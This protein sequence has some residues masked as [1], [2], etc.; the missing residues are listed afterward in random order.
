MSGSMM[1]YGV[2]QYFDD[3]GDPL[4]GGQLWTYRAGSTS[5]LPTYREADLLTPNSNPVILDAAGRATIF[6][7]PAAYKL[8]LYDVGDVLIWSVDNVVTTSASVTG[9]SSSR[10]MAGGENNSITD[11]TFPLGATF[12]KCH[13]GSKLVIFDSASVED[14]T[15][16]L[17]GM[18]FA[19][20]GTVS[21]ALFNLTDAPDVPMVTMA[22]ASPLGVLVQ[23]GGITFPPT[24]AF[25]TYAVKVRVSAGVGF[26]WGLSLIRIA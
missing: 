15:Y 2:V 6:G 20:G 7:Q 12:D 4:A 21:A 22:T 26:V 25:K 18:M 17:Q 24:G 3:N 14:G 5:P 11:L 10:E 9:T 1:P 23:S 16:A 13:G 8:V 19:L